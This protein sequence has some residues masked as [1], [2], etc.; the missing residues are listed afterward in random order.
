MNLL[1]TVNQFFNELF[2]LVECE[3]EVKYRIIER[4]VE[5][6]G[7][8]FVCVTLL[9]IRRFLTD[10]NECILSFAFFVLFASVLFGSGE[11]ELGCQTGFNSDL[12][13]IIS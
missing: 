4:H 7:K 3:T 5:N 11:S 1:K 12:Y 9:I 10:G 13:K 8:V 2:S 6:C